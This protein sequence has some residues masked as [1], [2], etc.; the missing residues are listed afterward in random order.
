MSGRVW[1]FPT[2]RRYGA[3]HDVFDSVM[4]DLRL[5]KM[6]Y[7]PSPFVAIKGVFERTDFSD[8]FSEHLVL[9]VNDR[10]TRGSR[11]D[12]FWIES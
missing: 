10:D 7:K 9:A 6:F 2:S 11:F 3:E 5:I 8:Q 12:L 4:S 1:I